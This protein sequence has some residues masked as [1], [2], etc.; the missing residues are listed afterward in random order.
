VAWLAPE[1][2]AGADAG[3]VPEDVVVVA[4]ADPPEVVCTMVP[5]PAAAGVPA[6]ATVVVV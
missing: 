5:V 1:L 4:T 2:A 6:A 3:P